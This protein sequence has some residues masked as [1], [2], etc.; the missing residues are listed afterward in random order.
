M[1][2]PQGCFY[3]INRAEAV[4]EILTALHKKTGG[5]QII[6]VFS[7]PQ[8]NAKRI[9]IIARKASRSPAVIHQGITIH[10]PDGT[11]T[12]QAQNIL[13]KGTGF[14]EAG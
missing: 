8:Q 2:K 7:K 11:Y 1:I 4:D 13:R 10:A 14:F 5:I 9:M 12:P 3:M 6:P